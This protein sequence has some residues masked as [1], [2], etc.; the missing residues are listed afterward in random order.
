[1]LSFLFWVGVVVNNIF[2]IAFIFILND[3]D[4]RVKI[5]AVHMLQNKFVPVKEI[6]FPG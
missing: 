3:I 4:S 6:Y 1:M 5:Q 2:R